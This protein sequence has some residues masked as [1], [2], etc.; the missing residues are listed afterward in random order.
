[1]DKNCEMNAYE[2]IFEVATDLFLTHGFEKT[3]IRMILDDCD[4]RSGSLYYLFSSKEEILKGGIEA[5]YGDILCRSGKLSRSQDDADLMIIL[6]T[7]FMLDAASRSKNLARLLYQAHSSW[8]I[9]N[10]ILE[11]A[12][13]WTRRDNVTIS[14]DTDLR[15]DFLFL[16]GGVGNMIGECYHSE[17]VPDHSAMLE[18]FSEAA[19]KILGMKPPEDP[20]SFIDNICGIVRS[21]GLEFIDRDIDK[22]DETYKPD[23][24]EE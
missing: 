9:M 2:K 10:K 14:D 24:K 8:P 22:I 6:P 12:E 17:V 1:M 20:R 4:I 18:R 15:S 19:H 5:F 11:M 23:Q 3:T 13:Y 21:E 7:A 16:M